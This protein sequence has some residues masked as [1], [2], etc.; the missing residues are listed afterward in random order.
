MKVL[1]FTGYYLPG[2]KGGGPVKTIKNLINQTSNTIDYQIITS[3]M[4]LGDIKP[5]PNIDAHKWNN[6]GKS[7]VFYIQ[8]GF[9]GIKQIF[10]I[11]GDRDYD[12][13]YLNSFFS[14]RFSIIPLLIAKFLNKQ[15]VLAPRGEFSKGAL[16]LKPLKKKIF[17]KSFKLLNLDKDIIFQASS[18]YEKNDILS[19]L[20]RDLDIVIAEN[21][22][23]QEFSESMPKKSN[24]VLKGVFVSRI[25]PIKNLLLALRILSDV[26]GPVSYNIYGPIEDSNYWQECKNVISK[27]PSNIT[28]RYNGELNPTE[29][30]PTL[31]QFDFFFLPTKGEN[32]GHVIA[33]ALCAGL[34]LV[35]SDATPWQNL[36]SF[37]IGWD[38]PL[39]NLDMFSKV[40]DKLIVMSDEQHY[41]MR[42]S[43]LTWAKQKFTQRNAIE[44]NIAMFRYAYNKKGLNN[45][46]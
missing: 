3:N 40:I 9:E 36:E 15:V 13:V 28:V 6:I 35:I 39:D 2:F 25:A 11:L 45:A 42:N 7:K 24:N 30:I 5:Y 31:T 21:I 12:I 27:L 38:L 34:P 23:S 29:I 4:D 26:K 8:Q 41:K 17:I 18:I 1:V 19:V 32:Y 33:E 46:V 10:L 37:G 22:G 43:V 20:G 44:S 14:P 16:S